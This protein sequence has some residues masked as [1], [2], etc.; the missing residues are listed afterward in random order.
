VTLCD[1]LC[2]PNDVSTLLK[3]NK[4]FH[5]TTVL[6]SLANLPRRIERYT[7]K[8]GYNEQLGTGQF[9]VITGLMCLVKWPIL[10]RNLFVVTE[11]LLTTEFHYIWPHSLAEIF[12]R[13]FCL[14]DPFTLTFD[15]QGL[16]FLRG[17]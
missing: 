16:L 4:H 7:V 8:L 5:M 9:C 12:L 2:D 15:L 3:T 1:A 6:R 10:L 11:C 14:I 17:R 13:V